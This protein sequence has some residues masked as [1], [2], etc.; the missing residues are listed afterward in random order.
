MLALFLRADKHFSKAVDLYTRA[1]ELA[2]DNAILY[3]NRAA[4]HMRLENYGSALADATL[5]IDRDPKYI[6]VCPCAGVVQERDKHSL[7][8][9]LSGERTRLSLYSGSSA[10]DP[11]GVEPVS[12]GP[13]RM[14][15][16]LALSVPL[17]LSV[18]YKWLIHW[19][20]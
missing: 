16:T 5:A 2:P 12:A 18:C 6:K 19:R 11:C 13:H 8:F 15:D 9:E 17:C 7:A 20:L 4:A 1:I 10:C 14:M 3:A